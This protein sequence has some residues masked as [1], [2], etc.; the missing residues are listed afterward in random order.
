MRL[1]YV[2][3]KPM[4]PRPKK[5]DAAWMGGEERKVPYRSRC[6]EGVKND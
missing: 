5:G 1:A 6:W 3:F 2:G 4:S